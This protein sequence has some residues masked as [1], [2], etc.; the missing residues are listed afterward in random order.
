MPKY[1]KARQVT[2]KGSVIPNEYYD[3][4]RELCRLG[5]SSKEPLNVKGVTVTPYDFAMAYIIKQREKILKERKFGKQR[6][7]LSVV[8]KGKKDGKYREY[9]FHMASKSEGLGEGTGIPAAMGVMLMQQ[10]KITAKGV[11]PPEA[12]INPS[13]LIGLVPQVMKLDSK[14]EG[15]ESFGGFVVQSVDAQ[16]NIATVDIF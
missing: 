4:T 10:G 15:G 5:L 14:K 11:L 8:V 6:G 13:D 3:L 9:R 12:C 1:I 7:C 2:N 16:G